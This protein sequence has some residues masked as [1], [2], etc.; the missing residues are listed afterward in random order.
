M[1]YLRGSTYIWSDGERVHLW[2]RDGLDHWRDTELGRHAEAS[3]VAFRVEA[4]DQFVCMR[5]AELVAA[6]KLQATVRNALEAAGGNFG[7]SALSELGPMIVERV[8]GLSAR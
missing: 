2:S 4:L 1:A 6:G 7:C 8:Q 5:F 3:G